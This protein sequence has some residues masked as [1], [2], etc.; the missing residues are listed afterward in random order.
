MGVLSVKRKS[1]DQLTVEFDKQMWYI[2]ELNRAK[3]LIVLEQCIGHPTK[4]VKVITRKLDNP[5]IV[6]Y[7][8]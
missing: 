6:Y 8:I 1:M 2:L 7:G 3:N 4:G 5:N